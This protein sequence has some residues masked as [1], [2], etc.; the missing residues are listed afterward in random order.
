MRVL[1]VRR[2]PF[3]LIRSGRK[4][5]EVRVAYASVQS[6]QKDEWIQLVSHPH[7]LRVYVSDKRSYPTFKEML[8]TEPYRQIAPD[9]ASSEAVLD[10]LTEIYPQHKENLGVIV[11]ELGLE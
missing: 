10:I 7:Q 6:I 5:L 3:R 8:A 2:E 4:T 1:H 11:L 9:H